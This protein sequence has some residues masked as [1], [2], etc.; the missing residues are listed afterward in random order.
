MNS[1]LNPDFLTA[2]F[3]MLLLAGTGVGQK[4]SAKSVGILVDNTGSMRSQIDRELEIAKEIVSQVD[5]QPVFSVFAFASDASA[6]GALAKLASGIQCTVDKVAISRT[7]DNIYV[8]GGQTRLIDSVNA[9]AE[10]LTKLPRCENVS[11]ST[12]FVISDGEDRASE[13]K[14]D[15]LFKKIKEMS[16]RVFVVGLLDN[17]GSEVGFK[18][19]SPR[20]KARAFLQ[21]LADTTGGKAVFPNSKQTANDV[22][23]ELLEM[24]VKSSK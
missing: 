9:S 18:R 7:I 1:S 16:L 11:E 4:D 15:E 3:L 8:L 22:V 12:L 14:P 17:V 6:N 19:G 23:N 24:T 20:K 2:I 13:L 21:D 10:L 5:G